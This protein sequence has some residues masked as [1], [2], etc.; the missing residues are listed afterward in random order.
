MVTRFKKILDALKF[1][2]FELDYL[3]KR[4]PQK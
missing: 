2:S 4:F 1:F 3:L